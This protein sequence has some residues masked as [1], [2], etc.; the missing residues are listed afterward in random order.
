MV[1]PWFTEKLFSKAQIWLS[2]TDSTVGTTPYNVVAADFNGDGKPDLAVTNYGSNT[3][4][5]FLNTGTSPYFPTTANQTLTAVQV[6]LELLPGDFNGD[7]K[8]DLAG[9]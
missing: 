6:P 3:V 9:N 5:I 2:K 1:R 8:I 4:S 7:G